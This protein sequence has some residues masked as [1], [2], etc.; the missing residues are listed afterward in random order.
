MDIDDKVAE[1]RAAK[2]S[3]DFD[4]ADRLREEL[5]A[6]GHDPGN[7]LSSD[8]HAIQRFGSPGNVQWPK[9]AGSRL[10]A[11]KVFLGAPEFYFKDYGLLPIS[12][13][14]LAGL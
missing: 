6:A 1:W 7:Q 9:W 10:L 8:A 13:I 12:K 4:T 14:A 2:E 3:R 5:R 11:F